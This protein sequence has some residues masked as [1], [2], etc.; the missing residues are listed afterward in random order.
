VRGAHSRISVKDPL[1]TIPF[2]FEEILG[3][4]IFRS[5]IMAT[6]FMLEDR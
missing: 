2:G 6:P 4:T 5:V 3:N 1:P